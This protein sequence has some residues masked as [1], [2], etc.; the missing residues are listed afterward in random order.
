MKTNAHSCLPQKAGFIISAILLALSVIIPVLA[1]DG[2]T[3]IYLPIVSNPITKPGEPGT[4]T[5]YISPDGDDNLSGLTE[6]EGWATFNRAWQ[7]I[8]P[9]DTLILLDGIYYQSLNPNKRNGEP[10]KPI[11]I[12]A[13]NDGKVIIDGQNQRTPVKIGDTWP[14]PIGDHFI[15]EG[16]VARNSN[17]SVINIWGSNN[18]LRRISAYDA[19]TD[20]NSFGIEVAYRAHNNL[21]EDCIVAGSGRK[22]ILIYGGTYNTIRRCFT[23]WREWDGREDGATWPWG[24]NINIYNASFNIVE[25]SIGY[26]PVPYRSISIIAN[27]PHCV[28]IE[29]MV[30]GSIAINAAMNDDGTPI[31]WGD[32]R[33]QPTEFTKMR[34]FENWPG[35]RSGFQLF[36]TGDLSD[37]L[38]QDI[39]AYGNAGL[40]LTFL[41]GDNQNNNNIRV[42]RATIINNGLDNP[43]GPWRAQYGGIDTD[44]LLV[45]LDKFDKIEDSYIE[46]IFIDW[47]SY[48]SGERNTT[49]MNGEG[50]RLTHRYVDGV[51]TDIPLWPWPMEER[52]QNE[53]GISVT[54]MMTSLI[55]G[56]WNEVIEEGF[57]PQ[58]TLSARR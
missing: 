31:D 40:G 39:F 19:N 38:F 50:A 46:K 55:F 9:G 13:N 14:G 12:K 2:Y 1:N 27:C 52:I 11:T 26:G 15:L 8:Y 42:N 23:D 25:N 56:D 18:I 58:R 35:Q 3:Q 47:P 10:G 16:I 17:H 7:D 51:L 33:P 48:P 24:E 5:Y 22:M 37:N 44:A 21:I 53:L 49:S 20:T 43:I 32:T 45:E 30:L 4:N 29:N 28:A 54:E 34:D 57:L 41:Q 6:G 36:G